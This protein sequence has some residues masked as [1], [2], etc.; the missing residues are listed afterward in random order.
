M[1][2][3]SGQDRLLSRLLTISCVLTVL[4]S[5]L[6]VSYYGDLAPRS[7]LI[8]TQDGA[9]AQQLGD[10][11]DQAPGS[12]QSAGAVDQPVSAATSGAPKTSTSQAP[13][14]V[15]AA[16]SSRGVSKGSIKIGG[17]FTET[18]PYDGRPADY[19][20]RAYIQMINAEGGVNGRKIEY[21]SYDDGY[22]PTQ[23][24]NAARRLVEQ[25]KVFAIVGWLAPNTEPAASE[26]FAKTGIPVIGG[27]GVPQE[28]GPSNFF[29]VS[30]NFAKAGAGLA[31]FP[32]E[33]GVKKPAVGV[34]NLS[35]SDQMVAG[36]KR[37]IEQC[38]GL[39]PVT[40][41]KIDA[42]ETNYSGK[43]LSWRA[44]GADSILAGLDPMSYVRLFQ[45]LAQQ[46]WYPPVYIA[47]FA[48]TERNAYVAKALEK[49]H[50]IN[51]ESE[52][53]PSIHMDLPGARRYV[54]TL[55]KYYPGTTIAALAEMSWS[56]AQV[57][58]E[59][60]RRAGPEPTRE[61]FIAALE[62]FR[63]FKMD[64]LPP[65]TYLRG[66]QDSVRCV[67]VQQWKD[68]GWKDF[69]PDWQCW[70]YTPN[71]GAAKAASKPFG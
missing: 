5:L 10:P 58:V 6:L 17:I 52:L 27:L 38:K 61:N 70:D 20:A 11:G 55:H 35:Y 15:T 32:C 4:L 19:S 3:P 8:G 14:K 59:G 47:G 16:D 41:E 65:M 9:A 13:R 39:E 48:D 34:V 56:G 40:Y 7:V 43:I 66:N 21:I 46:E 24:L 51:M 69:Y 36:F 30:S 62:T 68:G 54:E 12:V 29:S 26:Y 53:L 60:L 33:G 37:G 42:T 49:I 44:M 22:D 31:R 18:G 71:G 63:E 67:E 57:F 64:L 25:D 1:N 50:V 28:F 2:A 23:G 45:A